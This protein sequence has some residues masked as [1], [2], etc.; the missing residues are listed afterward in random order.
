M[1]YKKVKPN[2][3]KYELAQTFQ[4]QTGLEIDKDLLYNYVGL[5]Q[6]GFL[7][8]FTGYR[9]DGASGVAI[10]T[11]NFMIGS[12]VHDSLYQLMRKGILD[13]SYRDKVDRL[14]EKICIDNGMSRLRAANVYY[15]V[16]LFGEKYAK[17][18]YKKEEQENIIE[19]P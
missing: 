7:T 5:G 16:K 2:D 4:I 14:L 13:I 11:K 12:L 10:D 8:I 18:T 3:Y 9:W 17:P 19:I 6:K 15:A 1:L